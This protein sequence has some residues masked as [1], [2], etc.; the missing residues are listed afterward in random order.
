MAMLA[1]T[2]DFTKGVHDFKTSRWD[3]RLRDF[4]GILEWI[5]EY[6]P[7]PK[8]RLYLKDGNLTGPEAE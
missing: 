6:R 4:E 8:G 1:T 5:N 2:S 7:N 3:F